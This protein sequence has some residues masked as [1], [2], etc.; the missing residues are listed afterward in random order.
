MMLRFVV[1]CGCAFALAG[2]HT[3]DALH[4]IVRPSPVTAVAVEPSEDR[5]TWIAEY[6]QPPGGLDPALQRFFVRGVTKR[7]TLDVDPKLTCVAPDGVMVTYP[8]GLGRQDWKT[9][10][11][12]F[13][14][15]G[16]TRNPAW[17]IPSRYVRSAWQTTV[18]RIE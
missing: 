7:G 17:V 18:P 5:V 8:V 2:C 9:P 16:K 15:R 12:D 6:R 1:L 14:I 11:A 3:I 13:R 10:Q 4:R